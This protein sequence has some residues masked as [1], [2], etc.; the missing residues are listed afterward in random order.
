MAGLGVAIGGVFASDKY[1]CPNAVGVD[2][3]CGMCAVPFQGLYKDDLGPEALKK[4]H[5]LL[6]ER[7]PTAFDSHASQLSGTSVVLDEIAQEFPPAGFVREKAFVEGKLRARTLKQLGT[8]GGGNHF[9]EISYDETRQIW[10]MLH[11]GSRHIGNATAARYDA[12]AKEI[13]HKKGLHASPGLHYLEIE[14][15]EGQSYLCD[16]LFCQRYA[17]QN[18]KHMRDI[19]IN[20]VNEVT[21]SSPDES[22]L[23]LCSFQ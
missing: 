21:T 10:A 20:V 9:I 12:I 19:M 14:S 18:R 4:I 11:S 6:R 16:M 23:V 3:G 1:V 13:M 15:D 8:L 7:I 5:Q 2:I 17:W 22:R